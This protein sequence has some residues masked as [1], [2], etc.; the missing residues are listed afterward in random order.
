MRDCLYAIR[1]AWFRSAIFHTG[2]AAVAAMLLLA[3]SPAHAVLDRIKDLTLQTENKVEDEE[4]QQAWPVDCDAGSGGSAGCGGW[5]VLKNLAQAETLHGDNRSS[6]ST[7][8][9][10]GMGHKNTQGQPVGSMFHGVVVFSQAGKS[11]DGRDYGGVVVIQLALEDGSPQCFARYMFLDRRDLVRTGAEVEPGQR[12]GS[13]AS[14]DMSPSKTWWKDNWGNMPAQVKIDIGCD[15]A[16]VNLPHFMP[17]EA[18]TG[19][20][21]EDPNTCPLT[22]LRFPAPPLTYLVNTEH[23]GNTACHVGIRKD[24]REGIRAA[25]K[26]DNSERNMEVTGHYIDGVK[27]RGI[28]KRKETPVFSVF[29]DP[30]TRQNLWGA[31]RQRGNG[32]MLFRNHINYRRSTDLSCNNMSELFRG[33]DGES[34]KPRQVRELLTHCTNQYILGRAPFSKVYEQNESSATGMLE[35]LPQ[36]LRDFMEP[37]AQEEYEELIADGLDGREIFDEMEREIVGVYWR[38]LCQPLR[39]EKVHFRDY[40]PKELITKAWEELLIEWPQENEYT[41]INRAPIPNMNINEYTDYPYERI[42]DPSNPYSP[43]HIFAETERERY[44]NYGVQC[45]ATPVDIILGTYGQGTDEDPLKTF[46]M[47]DTAFHQCMRCRIELNETKEACFAD[48]YSFTNDGGCMGGFGAGNNAGSGE[49]CDNLDQQMLDWIDELEK[50]YGLYPQLLHGVATQESGCSADR[51]VVSS[52]GAQGMFQFMPGTAAGY[53]IDPWDPVEAAEGAARYYSSSAASFNCDLP[54]ML[55]SYNCGPGCAADRCGY[56]GC[57]EAEQRGLPEETQGYITNIS[58]M[59][60]NP[61]S[62]CSQGGPYPNGNGPTNGTNT[63]AGGTSGGSSGGSGTLG[64]LGNVF[65]NSGADGTGMSSVGTFDPT[66]C[67][68]GYQ[69]N[70]Y[71][72]TASGG[73]GSSGS[74]SGGGGGGGGKCAP[75]SYPT[76]DLPG[77]GT[78][79]CHGR[80]FYPPGCDASCQYN[81]NVRCNP[82]RAYYQ[83]GGESRSVCS[84]SS[85][86][87]RIHE[88]MDIAFE[89]GAPVYASADGVVESI[90]EDGTFLT[91]DH[92]GKCID[93]GCNKR[94]PQGTDTRYYHMGKERIMVKVGQE[95]SRC[96]QIGTVGDSRVEGVPHLHWEAWEAGSKMGGN[97]TSHWGL[98]QDENFHAHID[99]KS[100]TG[101]IWDAEGVMGGRGICEYALPVDTL[102]KEDLEPPSYFEEYEFPEVD[103]PQPRS[104]NRGDKF[105]LEEPGMVF[106]GAWRECR[107]VPARLREM[108][109]ELNEEEGSEVDAANGDPVEP[110]GG[111]D[112][113][114]NPLP[115][116]P[117][118]SPFGMRFHPIYKEYRLHQG[119]DIGTG[120]T[121]PPIFAVADGTVISAGPA[122]GWGNFVQ[123]KHADGSVSEYAHQSQ[124]CPQT[125]V[126]QTVVQGQVLGYVGTTGS[127]TGEHLHFNVVVNGDYTDPQPLIPAQTPGAAQC[128]QINSMRCG[129]TIDGQPVGGGVAG[130]TGKTLCADKPCS[131]RYDEADVVSQCA[132]PSDAGG[133]GT[134]GHFSQRDEGD[135]GDCCYKITAPVTSMNILKIRPGYNEEVLK[136]GTEDLNDFIKGGWTGRRVDD[137][138]PNGLKGEGGS[139]NVSER[140]P[141]APEGYTF[142]EHFRNHRP[143]MRWWDTGAEAGNILQETTDAA[144]DAGSFDALVGVGVEQNNCG[145]GGW[146]RP[147]QLDGNT[148]WLELKLYQ[149]RSQHMN[150]LRCIARYERVF[151]RG[152]SE[153]YALRLAGGN[154]DTSATGTGSVGTISL[155]F[156]LGWRGYASENE[157]AYRFPYYLNFPASDGHSAV[158]IGLDSA[159]PG[160]IIV[161]DK[162]VTGEKRLQHVAYVVRADN[163]AMRERTG[164][165]DNQSP[166]TKKRFFPAPEPQQAAPSITVVD[167]NFGRYPDTCGTTNWWATGPERKIYKGALPDS[168][169]SMAERQ[170]V[171]HVDCGN[172]DLTMCSEPLWGRVKVYR[173]REH[174]RD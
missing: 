165:A 9:R 31:N 2:T 62:G 64:G 6:C 146:G 46:G 135:N 33:K 166:L 167:Y 30:Q 153:D 141:G 29:A 66:G 94:F 75:Y 12:I 61:P 48:P 159:L 53:N 22:K 140:N 26:Q 98:A 15:E 72:F 27:P 136:P 125:V 84:N 147:N 43:R 14:D 67:P 35:P 18:H 97:I 106:E 54:A 156:P 39:M 50:R 63:G 59:I 95:V 4:C 96:Q 114:I 168:M 145:I 32:S 1:T 45:A 99:D 100:C 93:P 163:A 102:G 172:P 44:S 155:N 164:S 49:L 124:I 138:L 149:A 137:G 17:R 107:N 174:V 121:T 148:S 51:G 142:H 162:D 57:N 79:G 134:L 82:I 37:E 126:G 28:I 16:L 13:V 152:S 89:Y 74:G 112:A 7:G 55:A 88:G 139:V 127:S 8:V 47:R 105:D 60:G 91:V 173:P 143:Y 151:K 154:F 133:C 104:E 42:N 3:P 132:F 160:D 85:C 70:Q 109:E 24:A 21:V 171:E 19:N 110:T 130:G 158:R 52:A 38:D 10:I 71:S 170:G 103:M 118:S 161:W 111:M 128:P 150:G 122:G 80:T 11:R 115:C 90:N 78:F 87:P 5:N 25:P 117:M 169:K 77:P 56:D 83:S 68:A 113:F 58:A 86:P 101:G 116:F 119:I 92:S 131:V 65:G 129:Q 157:P 144:S 76:P 36:R 23:G 120:G 123:V 40:K 108:C 69:G 20:S 34:I 81:F 41:P 73:S